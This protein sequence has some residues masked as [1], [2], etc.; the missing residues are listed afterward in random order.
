LLLAVFYRQ[1]A[2]ISWA[3]IPLLILAAQDLAHL[4]D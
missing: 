1:P 3:V 2:E 4:R